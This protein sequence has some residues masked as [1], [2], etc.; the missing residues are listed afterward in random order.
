[1]NKEIINHGDISMKLNYTVPYDYLEVDIKMYV[2]NMENSTDT[3]K[4]NEIRI[5]LNTNTKMLLNGTKID[6]K[7][8]LIN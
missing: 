4:I 1:L 3:S 7:C 2:E 5:A 6:Y 8:P